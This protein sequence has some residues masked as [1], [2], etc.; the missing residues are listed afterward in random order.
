MLHS[1]RT[2]GL[3]THP[4]R[5]LLAM[6]YRGIELNLTLI[7]MCSAKRVQNKNIGLFAPALL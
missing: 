3:A 6:V 2:S 5:Y 7:K 4:L 1:N